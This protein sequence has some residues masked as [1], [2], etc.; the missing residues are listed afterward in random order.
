MSFEVGYKDA[1]EQ[2]LHHLSWEGRPPG[3]LK[4]RLFRNGPGKYHRGESRVSH[5]FDG[6]ALLHGFEISSEGVK[7]H[8][9][10]V[11][12]QEYRYAEQFGEIANP[13][14]A[15]D[16]CRG[17]FRKVMSAFVVD[18][19][20]NPN[21]S[22]IKQGK[23]YLALTE[24]PIPA[25]FDPETL[26]TVGPY[27]YDDALPSGSTT[28]H[29]HQDGE[30]LFNHVLEYSANPSFRMYYQDGDG[31]RQEYASFAE[32]N[33]GY[34]HSFGMSEDFVILTSGAFQVTP[35]KLLFRNRPFIENFQWEPKAKSRFHVAR[36]PGGRYFRRTYKADPFF[37]FHHVNS[38]QVGPKALQVD[39][40]G[41]PDA[42]VIEQ[43]RLARLDRAEGI[44]F[45]RFRRYLIDLERGTV[46]LSFQ[47]KHPLELPRIDYLRRN[48]KPYRFV[49]GIGADDELS[50]FYDRL[51]KLDVE[52][53]EASFWREPHTW[54]GEPVFVRD[55]DS[56]TEDGGILLS[57]VLASETERSFLLV[58]DASNFQELARCW[59]PEMVPHGFHGFFENQSH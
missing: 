10:F 9:H 31:P 12:S 26:R 22:L 23:Q 56:D 53:D 44:D 55:P 8:S 24:L 30:R 4:G 3:W 41:Y 47:S 57:V 16:P 21:V 25:R 36:K 14:F 29:P 19:T 45:G 38:V 52:T 27:V 51:I 5:W 59:L 32:S 13:G 2:A 11:R 18:A 34:V 48:T 46:E 39:L 40:V 35:L 17:L 54:P 7:Y 37:S 28:A 15:C 33:P 50:P 43:F 42:R 6:L 20:D 58:L 49:Y 1:A